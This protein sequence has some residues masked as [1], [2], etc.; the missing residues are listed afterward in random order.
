[1]RCT[2]IDDFEKAPGCGNAAV[3]VEGTLLCRNQ[4]PGAF[5]G[6]QSAAEGI[7]EGR[8]EDEV[9]RPV[10][11]MRRLDISRFLDKEK[12]LS[13][14]SSIIG[15]PEGAEANAVAFLSNNANSPAIT[16][17]R[18]AA[19]RT[20]FGPV[21]ELRAARQRTVHFAPAG[22]SCSSREFRELL[23]YGCTAP[24]PGATVAG[25]PVIPPAAPRRGVTGSSN[26]RIVI[27][28]VKTAETT[29]L[30]PGRC[31]FCF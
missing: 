15:P 28:C 8:Q 18:D 29:G 11:Q 2:D 30:S 17:I 24:D 16:T 13:E 12:E 26:V 4:N 6:N 3:W 23:M 31:C 1:M 25:A 14:G 21:W 20:K 10:L 7:A 9:G 27:P 19:A 5:G 22:R